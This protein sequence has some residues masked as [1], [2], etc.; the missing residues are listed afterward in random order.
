MLN[1]FLRNLLKVIEFLNIIFIPNNV[2][3]LLSL[4]INFIDLS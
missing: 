4:I 3:Q 2:K 1:P